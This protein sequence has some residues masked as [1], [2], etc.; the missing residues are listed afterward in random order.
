MSVGISKPAT[1]RH[2]RPTAQLDDWGPL[3]NGRPVLTV[4]NVQEWSRSVHLPNMSD[5][6]AAEAA[7]QLNHLAF[8]RCQ[9]APEFA[10]QRKANPS[11]KRMQRIANAL[12]V[13]QKD[14]PVVLNESRKIKPDADQSLT[15]A[16]L[17]LVRSHRRVID[18]YPRVRGRPREL[19]GNVAANIGKLLL[20]VYDQGRPTAKAR[21]AF[22]Q[23]AMGWLL[24]KAPTDGA[25]SRNRRRRA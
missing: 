17:D 4:A 15:K 9:W 21:D 3:V 16:L 7:R 22:V 5:A 11:A 20:N 18:A 8:M 10:E 23:C 19:T 12:A 24:A 1:L 6:A 2:A 25:I 14:L 13:L